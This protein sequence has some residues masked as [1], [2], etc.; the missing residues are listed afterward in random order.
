[1]H[2]IKIMSTNL[3]NK[4]AAGEIIE[5]PLSVVKELVENAL[6]SGASTIEVNLTQSGLFD[7]IVIDDGHGMNR[8][9]L[10]KSIVR[11]ATSKIYSDK[12][13]F[14]ISTLGFRGEALASMFAVSKMSITS[15]TDGVDGNVLTFSGM[16][17]ISTSVST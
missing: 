13:L 6:D 2:D 14:N 10:E 11:H 7:I 3:A 9:N 15:S 8:N 5:R 4:I 1:M 12:D 16:A 17:E